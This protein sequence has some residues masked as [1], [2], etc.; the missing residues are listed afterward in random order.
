MRGD[1]KNPLAKLII[2][3]GFIMK[4]ETFLRFNSK[5]SVFIAYEEY[6]AHCKRIIDVYKAFAHS[7]GLES[8]VIIPRTSSL[9]IRPTCKD[10]E[11]FGNQMC[12]PKIPGFPCVF[13]TN[14][15]VDNAWKK[16]IGKLGLRPMVRPTLVTSLN[17]LCC[18]IE[19]IY[20]DYLYIRTSGIFDKQ[21][22]ENCTIISG[23][24]FYRMLEEKKGKAEHT[25]IAA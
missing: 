6:E 10:I 20:E 15:L 9:T 8:T 24:E 11:F 12:E 5:S 14:T 19:F 25:V 16:V 4:K 3:G 1:T 21:A 23:S 13:R 17:S 7:I 18:E 2:R 22:V